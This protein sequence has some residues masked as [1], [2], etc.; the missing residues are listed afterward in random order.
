FTA[1]DVWMTREAL[2]A[3]S[4]GL[5]GLIVVKV[6]APGFYARQDVRTPVRIAVLCLV[7]TQMMNL[8]FIGQLKHAGLALS[9]GLGACLNAAL[10]FRELR[11]HAIYSPEPGWSGFMLKLSI[12]LVAMGCVL[13]LG[14]GANESWLHSGDAA[15]ITHLAGL[16]V[17]GSASY[18]GALA[19]MGLRLN[20]FAKRV[21]H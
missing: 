15:R 20:Q 10:L 7:A 4:V 2:V 8:L 1:H 5:I 18:F 9:I 21:A 13:W 11:R 14:M 17:L 16:V 6:L 19:L 3:Y 12:A